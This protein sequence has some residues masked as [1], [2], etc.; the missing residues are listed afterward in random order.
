MPRCGECDF[1]AANYLLLKS[2]RAFTHLPKSLDEDEEP[3]QGGIQLEYPHIQIQGSS[4]VQTNQADAKPELEMKV[5]PQ[6]Y[7]H[8]KINY[9]L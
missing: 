3:A 6:D 2:H 1:A 9:I 8:I 7:P 5:N 4:M